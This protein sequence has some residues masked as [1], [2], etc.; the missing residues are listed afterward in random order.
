[1]TSTD[2]AGVVLAAGFGSRLAQGAARTSLKPLTPVHGI[3]LFARTLQS[4]KLAG[5]SRAVV[6]LGHEAEAIRRAM[7][8]AGHDLAVEYVIN[9]R[10][11]LANGVS[12]LAA[13][14]RVGEEFVLTMADHVFGP[15][16]PPIAAAH[17]PAAGGAALLVDHDLGAVFDMDDATKVRE[18]AGTIVEIGKELTAYNCVDTG[19]FVCTRALL[20]ELEAVYEQRGNAP[21][22]DGVGRLARQGRMAAVDIGRGF[23]Q[24]VDTPEM[25]AHAERKLAELE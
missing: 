25:L 11:D 21:L 7:E 3:P 12:V 24:D 8:A 13:R 16:V 9:P 17:H 19:L 10:Y 6:V 4:L 14:D 1:M 15:E 20:T 23:W 5:C 22:S 2:R 18:E